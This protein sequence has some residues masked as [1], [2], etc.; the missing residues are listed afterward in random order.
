MKLAAGSSGKIEKTGATKDVENRRL[1]HETLVRLSDYLRRHMGLHYP[2]KKWNDLERQIMKSLADFN[3]S[4][5]GAFVD[6]LLSSV[7]PTRNQIEILASYLTIGETYFFRE[8]QVFEILEKQILPELIS[9]R[10]GN[11]RRIRIWSAGCCTGEEP[12]SIAILL[13]KM[14]PDWK[15]WNISILATDI[16]TRFLQKASEGLYSPWSFRDCPP[17]VKEGYFRKAGKDHLELMDDIRKRVTFAYHNLVDDSY[18]SLANQTNAMDMIFCRNVVMY[19][20][21]ETAK[22]IVSN[23]SRCLVDGGWMVIN[24]SE[25]SYIPSP[26]F[27]AVRFPNAVLY[28]KDSRDQKAMGIPYLP[29][30]FKIEEVEE[31]AKIIFE[32]TFKENIAPMPEIRETL[33][34]EAE[35]TSVDET[36]RL[37][38]DNAQA[39]FAQGRYGEATG[40]LLELI[41]RDPHAVKALSLLAH[42]YANQGD[43]LE[44]LK[45]CERA[46]GSDKFSPGLHYLRA[47]ILQEQGALD[48]S[49]HSLKRALYLDPDFVLAHFAMGILNRRRGKA[50]EA[51]RDFKNVLYLLRNC[52]QEEMLPESDGITA[53]R[54]AEIVQSI[55]R[56]KGLA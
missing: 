27:S 29:P 7:P 33:F 36:Q 56:E 47:S 19:F 34:V 40:E 32:Y 39:L 8:K 20:S 44:A 14:L 5:S 16:N 50:G 52:P 37:S 30:V 55:K 45:W 48:E 42:A 28:R 51:N 22:G 6:W 46:I 25:S 11:E 23:L 54:L 13:S 35:G 4:D 12:Y 31:P 18:P 21:E 43:L 9:A 17:W 49:I 10:R 3:F 26:P 53:G 24:P 1:P 2:P 15:N 41:S 38:C